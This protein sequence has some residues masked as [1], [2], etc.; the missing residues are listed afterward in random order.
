[1]RN[2]LAVT[3][4]ITF[5]GAVVAVPPPPCGGN[6]RCQ[7]EIPVVI[8]IDKYCEIEPCSDILLLEKPGEWW[9]G[10]TCVNLRNNW[11][12]LVTA[13]IEPYLPN[14]ESSSNPADMFDV[15][16]EGD[17]LG[18]DQDAKSI[19]TLHPYPGGYQF[20]VWVGIQ[21]PNFCIRASSDTP[22][23]VATVYITVQD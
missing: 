6:I 20:M 2:L 9:E 4:L 12:A 8:L 14:I 23:R 18:W 16:I 22:Q 13:T 5:A 1:M 19:I 10:S 3:L 17:L 11:S 15:V 21:S 7:T